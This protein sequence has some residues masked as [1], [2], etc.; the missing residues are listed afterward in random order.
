ML[1]ARKLTFVQAA[2]LVSYT[3]TSIKIM[4]TNS[5]S[6]RRVIDDCIRIFHKKEMNELNELDLT[7]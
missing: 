4:V 5:N 1:S 2:K 7:V 3:V 6:E